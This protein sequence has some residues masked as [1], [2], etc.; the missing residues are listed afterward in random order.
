MAN[1]GNIIGKVT[2][3]AGEATVRSPDG[4]IRTLQLG[5]AVYEGD[6]ITTSEGGKVEIAFEQGRSY[7]IGGNETLT[8][9]AQVYAPGATE[10][11]DAA[12]LPATGELA[13]VTQAII[14]GN[15]SLDA[16][17]EETAAGLSGGGDDN[18]SS[19]VELLRIAESTTPV[20]NTTTGIETNTRPQFETVNGAAAE[21]PSSISVNLPDTVTPGAASSAITITGSTSAIASG[22]TVTLVIQDSDPATPD[23][24]L[25]VVTANDGSFTGTANLSGLA[26]GTLTVTATVVDQNGTSS[27]ATDTAVMLNASP[28]AAADT[29]STAE[30]TAVTISAATL[31]AND[32]DAD[33]DALVISSV[34]GAVNGSVALVNGNIVFTP[35]ANY[36]GPASFSY[37]ISDGQGGSSTA[38]VSLNVGAVNDAAVITPGSVNLTETNL[39]LTASGT[40]A[41]SDV[42]SPAAFVPGTQTG[43][44]GSLSINAA[45]NWNYTASSAHNEFAAGSTYS[46]VFTVTSADGTTSTIT[47]NIAGTND[48]AVISTATVGLTE[49]NAA[50]SATGALTI[51]DADS[52]ATFVAG[53]IAGT[54]GS[55]ALQANGQWTYTASSA[56]DEFVGGATYS[57]SFVVTSADG[58]TSTITV[59]ILGTNDA[60]VIS[61]ASANLVQSNTVLSTAGTLSITDVDSA[62]SF[63]PGT[64]N[65][66]YGSIA[67]QA[68]GQWVYTAS[69]AHTEFVG[70]TNY[71]DVFTVTSADGT[72]STI[73]VNIL[74]TND[75]AVI[76]SASIGLTETDSVLSASGTLTISDVDSPATF[77]A[78]TIGGAYG[79]IDLQANGQWTYTASSAHNE[80]AAGTNYNEV[81]TVTSSDGTTSTITVNILG[82]ND[83][84]VISTGSANLTETNAV[85]VTTGTLTIVDPDN[86]AAFVPAT[87]SGTYG[88]VNLQANGQWTYTASSAHDEFVGG[89]TY[90]DT[91]TVT[92]VDG[93]TSTITVNILGTNDAAVIS[94]ATVNLTESDVA[95]SPTGVLSVS[96][97][98]TIS[99]VDS[100]AT[101][102][103]GTITG[104]YGSVTVQTNGQWTYNASSAHPEFVAGTTYSDVF[105]VTS[106]DGTTSTI[107]VNI[108]GTN[109]AAVIS[110]A[111][112]NLVETDSVLT[113]SGTLTI[114][115]A[116][117]SATFVA[118]TIGGTYG[119]IAIDANGAWNYTASSA[120]PEFVAGTNYSDVFTVTSADGT[121]STITVNI[122][123]TNDAA[124]ISTAT[125]NLT[126]TDAL[127]VTSGT[128][129][130]SDADSA[131]TFVPATIT[132]NYGSVTLQANGQWTYTASS[133]HPEFVGGTNYSDAFTV[134]SADG[135]TSTIT[136]NILGTN[137]AA[138]ISSATANLVE[139]NAVLSTSGT[140]NISD[141][142]SAATF[143]AGTIAGTYGSVALQANGQWVYTASSAHNEFVGGANYSDVFTVTSADGT[144]S[145]I[146]VNILGINDAAVISSATVPLT[147]TGAVLT[148]TGALTISDADSA[149][150]FVPGTLTGTHGSVVLQAN[151]QWTYTASSAHDE[152][153]GGTTY[154]DVFTVTSADGTTSTITVNILGTNDAAVLSTATANL[155]ETNAV[156]STS[157]TLTVS[158]V[159]SAASFNAGTITGTYGSIVLQADGQWTY[160]AS[161]AHPEF[162]AGTTYSDT[163]AVTSA[164]G[165]ATTITVN[166]LGT[167]DTAVISTATANLIENGTVLTANGSLSITDP[168]SPA[169]F[170]PATINGSYGSLTIDAAGNWNYTATSTHEEFAGGTT[171]ADVFTVTSADGSTS[172]VTVN[173]VGSNGNAVIST[174]TVNLNETNAVLTSSGTLTIT[175]AD[176]PASF[177]AETI[178]GSYGSVT[179]AANGQWTYTASSAHNEF[180]GGAT[181]SDVFVVTSDDGTPS[182]ITVNILGTNDAA[183]LS[184]ATASLTET[185]AVLT[186]SGQLTISDVDNPATFAAGTISGTYGSVT[187]QANGQWVYNA[188]SAHNEFAAGSTHTDTFTVAATDGTTST[189]TISILGTNDAAVISTGS[190]S[191]VETNAVLSTS[192]TL[193]ISDA[194]SAATFAAGTIAG[195]YGSVA[196][197]SNGQWVYTASSAHNEFVGG[198][199][200]QDVFTV[201]S[202]DGTTSTITI[203]ILGTN[204]AAV[205]STATANLTET[206][207][208]LT[209]SGTLSIADADSAATFVP[210]TITG[211]YG[212]VNLQSNGQW[213][214]T[215]S[216]AH[217]E[218]AAGTTYSDVFTV[219]SADGTT[220]T[221]TVNILGTN[222]AAVIS[223]ATVN[224]VETNAV[225][226]A[227]GNLTVSDVDSAASFAAGTIG[228]A[229]GSINLQANGQWTYTA[230]SAHNE[231]VAGTN[232]QDVFTVAS[233]D[234]TT[235]TITVN[236]LGTN[237]A[238]VVS[239][240]TA[241][242]TETNAVLTTSG[243]LSVSDVDSA[244]SF[245]PAT[246]AGN[247][248][249][250]T[251]QA[252]G[253][254]TY[255]ASSAHNEFVAGT[256]YSDTFAVTTVDG[257]ASTITVNIVG[258][259]DAAV[260]SS[261]TVN[262]LETN[263]VL[264][265]AGTLTI[266]DVD[267]GASFVP[268][269]I[270]GTYGS[271]TIDASGNWNYTASSAHNE[272]QGSPS[273]INFY[274]DT[275]TVTGIDGTTSTITVNIRGTND[276]AVISTATVNLTETNAVLTSAGTLTISDLDSPATF[277]AGT[278]TGTYG[279]VNLQANGQWVYTASTAHNEFVGGT[280]YSDVF[281]VTSAD[282][283]TSTITVNILG[284]NDAAVI[285]TATANLTET[286]AVLSTSGTLTITDADSAASFNAGTFTGTYGSVALQT[287]GQWTYTASSAHNEFV[288]GTTYSD[289]F[290]VTSADGT[291]STIT[292]NILGTNDAAVISSAIVPLTETDAVLSASGTLT[293]SDA[294]SAASFNAGTIAG[295]YG[296]IALQANGQWVYT[297]SSAHNEFVGGTTYSDVFT[298]TSADGTVSTI[299]VNILGTND[300]A[301][302]STATANL[303]E[304]N[305][306]LTASGT[307]SVSDVDSAASFNAGTISGTYGSIA[308]QVNGQ[309]VYTASSAHNEF[310]GGTTYS[311]VFTVTSADGTASTITVNILGTNDAAVLSTATANLTETNAVLSA[312]GTLTI[313]DADSAASFNAGT[314]AG[315]YGSIALQANGQWT[316]TASSAH[317]EFVGGTTYSDVF[318]VTSADGTA[319]TITVN[320]LG[321]NDAA[322]LSTATANLTQT[323]A[324]LTTSGS[325]TV[326]DV[327]SPATFVAGTIAGTY[328]SVALQ[329][330][331]QWTYTASSA[332]GEFV[333]GTSYSD[334]FT[335]TSAD[336]TT[337]TIT[338]NI[339]GTNDAAVISTAT[340]NLIETDS[341]LATSGTLTI[342]DVDSAATFVAGTIAGA[343][344]SVTINAAGAWTYTASSAHPEFVGGT[345]YSDVFTVKSADGTSSTITV[346]ILGSNGNAVISTATANLTETNAVLTASG[347]LT[348]T[349]VDSAATFVPDTLAGTY[350]SVVLQA[351]G[352]WAYTASS[353]HNEFVG[354]TTYTDV[355]T[356]TSD[357][358]TTSTITVNILGTNDAAILSTATAS[359]VETN[360]VLTAS[361]TLTVSD[362][363]SAATFVAG[364]IPGT[365]GSIALQANGQWVYTAASAHNEFVGG[366]NYSEVF[367]VKSADGTTST[368][369]VNILGTN[370]VAVLSTA[371]ANLTETNAVL[372]ASGSLTISDVDSAA[373]F[374]AG[375]IAGTYGSI[376]LQSNGQWVYTASSAHNEF[377]GGTTYTDNFTVTSADGTTST[378]TVNILGTND[379]AVISSATVPLTETNA[380]LTAS[381]SLTITDADSAATFVAGTLTGTYGSVA[382]Q[383]NGQWTY[384]ASSAHNE[385]VGGATYSDVFTVTS[386]DGTT[387]TITVNILGTNDAA[388]LSSATVNLTE[389]DAVLTTSGTLSV[390]D[391]DSAAAFVAATIPGTYGSIAMQANGQWT[392]TASSAHNEFVGGTSYS[393]VFTVTSADGTTSTITVNILGANDAAVISSATVPLTETNAVLSAS[394]TL[395]LTDADSAATFVP[396][397]LTGTYGSVALQANGQWT[398]TASSAHNEFVGGTT[399]SD[400]FTVTSADGSTSTITVNI[401]GTN[402]AAVLSTA[403]AN[404]TETNSVLTASGTLTVSDVDSAASFNAG[405]IAGTYGSIV[406]QA[407]GQWT[408]TASTAHNEFVGGTTY[409]DTF[410]VTS[411]DG[412]ATT[413]TV[414]ILGTN[415]AAVLS[416]ATANLTETNAVLTASGT[417]TVTDVDSAASFNAGTIAGTYGSI[418][419]QANG[420]WTYTASS[421]HDEFVGGTTYSD[422][423][424]VTSADGTTSTITVNILGTNDAA[425]LSTAS[426]NL[427][428]T[429]AV[430]STS[431]TLTV[432]DVDS[433]A[434]FV[435]GTINGTYGSVTLQANGQWIYTASSAH[436]EFVGGTTYTDNFTVASADGTASTIT[437][438]IVGAND[439]AVI[440]S[441][442]V[443]LTETNA[444][445]TASGTL[446]ITDAD[447]A[448]TF[449]AG[450]IN[451]TYG[452]VALQANGQWVYTASSAHNEFVGGTTYTDNFTVKSAD[453]TTSTIT[454]NILGTNDA[455]VLSTATA[456]L[457]ETNAVLTA[458]GTLTV[459]DVDSAASFNAGT[460]AGT[461][462]SIALQANGQ[463]VYTASTAHN[464]FVGGTTYSDTFNVTSADG[465]ATTIT[466]NI[467]GTNDAAVL[468]TATANLT[469]T[470]AVL[471]AAGTL[472]VSDVDS[473]ASF[474]AGTIAGTYGSV[475]L[476][477]NGQWVYT[478]S[479]AH[480]EFVGGTTYTDTFTVTSADGTASNITVNILGTND[481]AVLSTATVNLT[482]TNAVLTASGTLTVS[483][484]DSAPSFNAGTIAGTYGSVALQANGQWVYTASSAH[485]E[486]VDGTTYTDSFTVTSADGTTSTITVNILGAND[487]AVISSATVPLTETNAVLTASGTLT[488]TDADSAATFV[489]GT[490]TGTYGS[491][492]LQANGQWTYTASSAHNEFV[493]GSTYSD[494]FT[495]TS[496][497]GTTSTITVNILGTNDAAVLSTATANLTE[498]N[499]VLTASGTL[500]V[501]DVDSAASF[502][503]GTIAGTYGS[504]AL[505]ANGQWVYTASSAHNEFVGGTSYSD[506]FTVTSADGT[507]TT[508]TVNILGTNDAAVLSTA[509]ANLTETNAVLTASG[510]LTVSDVD[511]AASFNAGTIAGTYGSI[512]LQANG[513]WVYTAS[514][515]HND[516]VG[517][518]TYSD[519]FNVTSV[520]G[521]AST[522]TVNILGTNDAAVLSTATANLT[523]T[524]AVLTA[525]GTLTVSDVDSAASFNAGTIAGTYG[526]IVLQANGQ[527]VYTASTAHNEFV[528]GT[529]Y[530]DTFNVTSADGTATTITVN[531][532]GTND[533]AVLSTATVN[534]TESNAVLTA[535]GTL[536]ISDVDSAASFNAGTIAGTYGSI[537]LQANGQWVY[538]ASTAHNEFVGGTTYSDTFNVTSADGSATTITVN[539][540]GTNDAAVLSTATSNLT[541]T[542]A[543]LTASG[544]LSISDVDSAAS[545]NAGTIT[546]TYG[547]VNL[548]S[549]GQWIYT[550]S[551]AHNEFVGGTTYSDNFTVTS[552]DG[553]SSTITVNILGTNDAAV[554]S[555]A[556]ANLTETNAVLTA[557]GTLTVS[558]VDSAASFTAGTIAG[559]YGSIALQA[560]GQWVYTASTA[561]NEF[562]GGTTYSDTFNVTSADGTATTITVNILG[563]NDAAV[564]STAT[565]NLT[566]TN[567]VL[568]A[569]GTLT[570]SDVDSAASF[571]AGT[572][573]GTYG[574]IALQANGQWVYTASTAHNEFVGGTTYSDTFNVTSADGT[575]TTITVNILGTNDAAVLS[576][577]TDNLTETNAVLTASGTLTVSD[578]DSA[579]SFNAGTIVGTYGSVALQ[580]NGQWVYTASSAHNE[581]VGGTTY[582]DTFTVTSADGTASTIT[583][584]ILGT[585]DAAV[586]STAT[587][588]L[589]ET[590]AVLTASG[591]LTVS[592]VDSAAS[593]NAGTIAGTYGSIA[594]QANGQWV[595]TASS[596]HN[597]FVYGTTYTDTFTVTS[598][599]GTAS[600]ITVNVLGTNDAA[601]ISSATVPLTETN[602][603]LTASGTLT[604]TDADSAA[605]F[606][607]G[608]IAGT[609]GSVALQAN[610][611]W[612]YTASSA[613]NEFVGGTTYS[614]VFTVTSADGTTSTITVNILGTND[615]AVLSTATA[616]L[617]ETNAVLTAT[618]T[619]TVSDVDSA[620]SFNAGTIAGAYGSI[621]LQA[622]GQWTYTASSAHNEFVGGTSYSD[623]FTVTSADGTATT[624]TV[625]ILGTNDAAVLSTAT[626]NLTETNAVLTASGTLTVS[627][628]DSA[629]SFNAGTITGTY[630]SIALQA[631]G[632]W[633][634]TAS[635][636]HNEFVGG[637]T[638]SDTFNVT[639][640]DGTATTITVNILGTNDAAVL[641]TATANLTE[642]NAALT[643]SGTLTVTD[644]DSAASFVA[645]TIAGTYG[646]V[647][648]QANGQWV[649]TAS[650][651]HN[652]F[653]GGTTYTDNFTVKSADGTTSTITVNILGTNDA[654][655]LSTAT[656]NLTETNAVLTASGTLTVSDVDSAASFNAGTI[657]GT[658]GSIALQA[659][660]QWVYTASTAH[661]EFVAGTT[662]SDTFNVTSADGTATTIT[663]NI[664]GTNDAAVL[665]TA[666][667]NLTETNAVLTASGTLTVSDVDSAASFNA[668]TIA[669]TYGSV[670]LQANG[671]WV[672]T[673][674]S[675]HNEFVGGTTYSDTFTVSSADGTTS[676]I[677]VNI[678]GTND[679]AVISTATAN[680]TE[681]NAVLTASGTLT[682]TDADSAATFVAGTLAGTYGSVALQANGQWTYT[683]STAHNE[684]VGGT[685]YSDTFTVTS[686]DGTTSTITV[687]ILGTNDAAV[688][689][690]AT[691]PLTETNAIL[692]ASGALSISDVD[693]AATFVAGT[694]AGTYGS[695]A[696]QANGQWVYTASTAHNEFVGGTTYSDTFTVT[697][698]D[699]TASTITV[700]I[701]GTNDAAVISTATVN[702]TETNA[703][704]TAAGTLGI[705]D[706]DSALTFNA[707]TFAGTYGSLTINTAGNW[708]YAASTAHNEFALGTTYTDTFTVTSADGTT[709]TVTVRIAG[710]NDA[711]VISTA[712][713]SLTETNAVLTTSGTLTIS[714]VDSPATFVAGTIAGTYGSV[715]LQA[716]GQWVYT[717]STAHNEFVGGTTYSDTF[718]VTSADGTTSTI[719]VN[720]L[721][722]NDA[723]VISTATAN[724]TE[725]NAVLTTSGTLTITDADSAAT[726]VA[727]TLAGTYGSVALQANGQWTYTASTAHN[728][729]VGGTTYS[730][731]FTVTSADGSTSTITVNILGT[732]DAAVL[733]SATVP[734][735]ET[736]AVLTASGSL[737]ISDVDSAASFVAGTIAGTYGSVALQAN[738]QW[739]YTASTAHNEF[740]GGTTYSDSFTVTSADGTTST[741]TVNI[742]GTNDAAVISTATIN[743]TETNAVLT[744]AGSLTISDVDSAATFNAGTIAGTYGSLTITAAGNW[745]YTASSAHNEFAGGTTYTDTF[746]VTSA[747]GSTSTVTVRIA[748]VND[749]AVISTATVPL[750]ETNAILSASGTL[751][752]SDADSPAT[753][754]A[755]TIAGT[756]GSVALQANGQW[757]YTASTAH[758]EFVGGTT[759]SDTFTVSSADGTTSTITVNILGTND[760]AV[761]STGSANLTESG[762]VL[763]ANGNLTISDVDSAATFAAGTIAGTY[764][765]LAITTA[766][767][768][769]YTASSAHNEFALG[770]NYTDTFIVTSADGT[771]STVTVTIAGT[772]DAAVISTATANLTETNAVLTASGTLTISDVDSAA[773]FVAGTIGGTYGSV[774]LQA[775]GQWVYTASTAHNEF[776][777]GTTYSDVFTV[778]SA[779]GTNSTI[780]VN[781][782]GTNDAAVLSTA[783]VALTETNAILST[784]GTLTVTD[785]DSS[786]TYV[787]GTTAGAY[788]SL[789]INA[790][791]AWT[792]TTS[793]AHNEFAAGVVYS[794]AIVVKSADGTSTTVTVNI[795]GTNDAAVITPTT[796]NLT[797]TNAVLTSSGTV[798][799]T[800]VD[801]P[802]TFVAG[803]TTGTYG[804]LTMA[805]NGSWTYAASTAH[806]EFAA[807][808]V[809]KDTFTVTSA[810]GT[811]STI[812]VNITG[813][814]DAP[815]GRNDVNSITEDSGVTTLTVN[816]ANGVILS[817][818]NAAGRDSDAEGNTMS[819]SGVRTG[820]GSGSG[821][822]GTVGS[823]LVGAYGSLTLAA[824]GSYSYVLR[825]SSV[826][827]QNLL[828]GETAYDNFTYTVSDGKGGFDT[829]TLSIAVNGAMDLTAAPAT[830]TALPNAANGLSG[831][832]Y[833]YNETNAVGTGI[834]SHSDDG[835]ATF[836]IHN[837]TGNLNSVEDMYTIIDGRN[838]LAGGGSVV[839][840]A[841]S[842]TAGAADVV[843]QARTLS[844]GVTQSVTSALGSNSSVAAGGS[845]PTTST[846][847]TTRGL[848]NFLYQDRGTGVVQT[849]A[850]NTN[851]TSGLGNT[852]D[853]AVRMSGQFYMQPGSYDFRVT[854]DDGFRLNVAGQTLLEFDGNQSPTTRVFRNVYL[855]N[856]EGGLQDI[857]L[858]YWEQ[859]G[860]AILKI[861]FKAS[862]DPASA[863]QVLSLSNTA[864]FS[865]EAAPTLSDP[866]IQDLV[867]DTN[868][869]KWQ[870][871]TG[872][873]L[874]GDGNG[875][876]LTGG[877]GRDLLNGNGGN[878][879]LNG[880]G[881]ADRLDG[882]AG[883]D[884]LNGGDGNDVLIGGAGTDLLVGGL[885]DDIYVLS[886]QLDTLT[887]LASQGTDTVQL[888]AAYTGTSYTLQTNFENLTAQGSA[889]FTLTGNSVDNRIEGNSGANIIDGGA[890]NDYLIGGAGNDTLT[891][892]TGSDVFAWRLADRG[893]AGAP[894][895]DTIT[896]FTYGGG[897]SNVESGTAGV[898][899]GGGD[900]LDLRDLL[901]GEHTTLSVTDPAL[902]QVEISNLQ[903]FIH[904]EISG[905]N[906]ILHINSTG[907]FS[908]TSNTG[909][910]QTIT[911]TGVN[912]YTQLGVTA[913]EDANLLKM[914]LKMGTLRID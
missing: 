254:W 671:Q 258:T 786:A 847:S 173:I 828:A 867:Y 183:V 136:V 238:A 346:N 338:V 655:V 362:V 456:N 257:T 659:N 508:V 754:V 426:V 804:S 629:A 594:L 784:S 506:T 487:A 261:A 72:T 42:D 112:A 811:T 712:S 314:I 89:A 23:V 428:E 430:L 864:M 227:S 479:S 309:W 354:G 294:D 185:N 452:S 529:T 538:T 462:G 737:S 77:V 695:V 813:T 563:T 119:S 768:W 212:S 578:V 235:S 703:V 80:F 580:A 608:T 588:N 144:T 466:V 626:A 477:A 376:A 905:S 141:A 723:A 75:A 454:V 198:T 239:T 313:S 312:T 4:S 236:I 615:A 63:V 73:T 829:A 889:N 505:Q 565:V 451:G 54:Y 522:I 460:I 548:Q 773:T 810:D 536:T 685:T 843:F 410:N 10:T 549:N 404:L 598:A 658:Y 317:N 840:T 308:L 558:D 224:L 285:S 195:T 324:V 716:N 820:D 783:T 787:A 170:N 797:E 66:T 560:N 445:L 650:S 2:L 187:L 751:T 913:G 517:G 476:H 326:S 231:F 575:A 202:A 319:S 493:G 278:L 878:D 351:N 803:T 792:Y 612:T 38:T 620:A 168:D 188:S 678:L 469:E 900:V 799:I 628:V 557:S 431:G 221:I 545:F 736:N 903:N 287:N 559:T 50:L 827:V 852:T 842:G 69:S 729:F 556:T 191:L 325:L 776:V 40:L 247:Y 223:T 767:A 543:V 807:G 131:A 280:T 129:S 283:T 243:T 197:Q 402:D 631:N 343:Y 306:V 861:E 91:F 544:T 13:D 409:S 662:Y 228:G 115:D 24:T 518:T 349:D 219:A 884:T 401:L 57:D 341:V 64:I 347:T 318:T 526:S 642:T 478:A 874:D 152:F 681:T 486:F 6:V 798:A 616:N 39:P 753:F 592:D 106:A 718:I 707:G 449:V 463:W 648:L 634:Y 870:M 743:L 763:T 689:S 371:T 411:A 584:N 276:A 603:V 118:G 34:Q 735:T 625:N 455:A 203:N 403:T 720:I 359:L 759:Y 368:I 339:L 568:T 320:I 744:A 839:G 225:L 688:L 56:H 802:L 65:G 105:T 547:S 248:G 194:D 315:A 230:I 755:G 490:V 415:D 494:V 757:V 189:I 363:D 252:N 673:A 143:V 850:G 564:L 52:P 399:Y 379:A 286:N 745:N 690:S 582:T 448:T 336:G 805:S 808:T 331:G 383:A 408:Y 12:L 246:V 488:I 215:A 510:T 260:I 289:V 750:T 250:V 514:S 400:T 214:Y 251:L 499:A 210:A 873:R 676:T 796:V 373:T 145:T 422:N 179:I 281:T 908:G 590:N 669:G 898:A 270:N 295:N 53:T 496:A 234:G 169:V 552:A 441:A 527:W 352:N 348:I 103:A 321:T 46:D 537:A 708:T 177:T 555:T 255:T 385:F 60:A 369:T 164:D 719:T 746:T 99:D 110:T 148:A 815:V 666:T 780:T 20:E 322:V 429:D 772:N 883:N 756:Y 174:A 412:T 201:A 229:Y 734:L 140:L 220:S 541:E 730:D 353:A 405:T 277:I 818:A 87:I 639:S 691:V 680:L 550:A 645:G 694:I 467:L 503:A 245:T 104:A 120:H 165:T 55:I 76:S 51:S 44:Y 88:S 539:I 48:A 275:F 442:T 897:N 377:V 491:V 364:T 711:A 78:G 327:D 573:A 613:H 184:S 186:T 232:Y 178:T 722:T 416:T 284:T 696:L 765:S 397:T 193:S 146:T 484:V 858:L 561:H 333:G 581:F 123:G 781:I 226:T 492:A 457:T 674:S 834:R 630:G 3:L 393:D 863:Y 893:T 672:Y 710:S 237:D 895:K 417:L 600:T 606:V 290:T 901:Q 323:N 812:V 692:T 378:I 458:S 542:N 562:V 207:A 585:N 604:I 396:G 135:T 854:A 793:T 211:T 848:A 826:E 421:A 253:Q 444:V 35:A 705:T 614:D 96:G 241:N 684:F 259:N 699:G 800:D 150:A 567:A 45:G 651:A 571:N 512:T 892:G 700:N 265:A 621:A 372:T 355:F 790:A 427:T 49:T 190:A 15:G 679:A 418:N 291:T 909:E 102:V 566:E 740:V 62:A 485:D 151:G 86:A 465:T 601:V 424:T 61:T 302:L 67:L 240:A 860:N 208:V 413:I 577:A 523:E 297:A 769:T 342:S 540:L 394:G 157:G 724:L 434:A 912:L 200:Y 511:S 301:V 390:S 764:G 272:F 519:T 597:E 7:V 328:G 116:D 806:D 607:A 244:G 845:L 814:N 420:Q 109:S 619:L 761:I 82:T 823:A 85:L 407:N 367:T 837:G 832:Y 149:A 749:A 358:G 274:N 398:Y 127:L 25:T 593:F 356:V 738:G 299:T 156:L 779:D 84:A 360:A 782:L 282:G 732:N 41:I 279:S 316:Y 158:D 307:L 748:G 107:T 92:S 623:T 263:A 717:A 875:N 891:G 461:Y 489:A 437:V 836:G 844:Y 728:E 471:T 419:L 22:S 670:A 386:A 513:Q 288:G 122:L 622:N 475:V 896:D 9:D 269:T 344:G 155:T 713:A 819:V 789:T 271:V 766:G 661:N 501:T 28:V 132:G 27:S 8:L 216:S 682:I 19:F 725:T 533:A 880:N 569:S 535:S 520:D 731:S 838:A 450:T 687:N 108:L 159:D 425:V 882:G 93:A 579:A 686:A 775:N 335:V 833:G 709:S 384:T 160:N 300:A 101:F 741:I 468:S 635:T 43:A 881:G 303:T 507:A 640:A 83:A 668:G 242:L 128:L 657:A 693:S 453:G 267:G 311:D 760:A 516:F 788:G 74:G 865:A 365:Y 637:T 36:N 406:L 480:N 871:R 11:H 304:T 638:Y 206:N 100:P 521:T 292:V 482:E 653:V 758:N 209:S 337:S 886:D 907:G 133:A 71:S 481:A 414:N 310:V 591:T 163:F 704:L 68:D 841:N 436:N 329:A 862:N 391:V 817:G 714:D 825:N 602:A 868:T 497:D 97:S 32:T 532:L 262:L 644:V 509:T 914:L 90:S 95:G 853:A 218:F 142:D 752:I 70:G 904:V 117:N 856:D 196:L 500:T 774:A 824:D 26:H 37:T 683:A 665:S 192:G 18:G 361:G 176:S 771:T 785:V 495:V 702:L 733:S 572:I 125:A 667:A 504:I 139:T 618:G 382:L 380:V 877:A 554:L 334:V 502:N 474:N 147:E 885:G 641:S 831:S 910:D 869:A 395:T 675:A 388:V 849:G 656:A 357:D 154:S 16:L 98:L 5:D 162:V 859:G 182:T 822:A 14:S 332:H 721:G 809:Y 697:S 643:A 899:V 111:T 33:G 633:V 381:G 589:T 340:A 583:V 389:T 906:T 816:A 576:T 124:V 632:Q 701:L 911:L 459:S 646:S 30:D 213:T 546:G 649:Y 366:T 374:V 888:D 121:T 268:A 727:G 81:F 204:D 902:S 574:S 551:S 647:A 298:V 515:A 553:T 470:N 595:Y 433:A 739:V 266:S 498:T 439:A 611:Q 747:D 29:I 167:N 392:Y 330:D 438:N 876:T 222:D 887:E 866:Q 830:L 524:N 835:K 531:I 175:D 256:T 879:T 599:D 130:I 570:V 851:N 846:T 778:T 447:S 138:V 217:N 596:A 791:G 483:D 126:E 370:D 345:T 113:A 58:T 464:E 872:S 171:Y 894:A 726:F 47:V 472:T 664:L 777:A 617:T 857:E 180:A 794:D 423:F 205:I 387:S 264:T 94:T 715:A 293:I 305:A 654:A 624:I 446:T 296:S 530:S 821:T 770:T 432:S 528:G 435:P 525:S 636:A 473:A 273:S 677:T 605:T 443:P 652:E 172:T 249:S 890:G 587:V 59:N 375:T 1:A 762:A 742:L 609:Y 586:L 795:T 166:I 663:V 855:S 161:S 660:G 181:Y 199:N 698:A 114:S 706:V 610:G 801:N 137:D 233:A 31:L 79:S 440:S 134:T 153:A 627:D 17:L 350:G 534:L 21:A